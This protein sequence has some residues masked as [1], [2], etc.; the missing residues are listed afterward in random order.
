MVTA[1][2]SLLTDSLE[3]AALWMTEMPKATCEGFGFSLIKQANVSFGL[4]ASSTTSSISLRE[5]ATA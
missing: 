4:T 3:L 5:I 2:E 1:P